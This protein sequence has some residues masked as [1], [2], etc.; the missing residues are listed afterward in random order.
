MQIID[1]S[2]LLFSPQ[3]QEKIR[4]IVR[5]AFVFCPVLPKKNP[6]QLPQVIYI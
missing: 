3:H 2:C 1:V 6:A 5:D 4:Y